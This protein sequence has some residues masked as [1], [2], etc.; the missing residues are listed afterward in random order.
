MIATAPLLEVRR[1][2]KVFHTAG[3]FVGRG[4]REVRA[5]DD[6]SFA[7]MAGETFGLVGESG[8]GKSTVARCVLN[9]IR[10]TAGEVLFEGR[11]VLAL[12]PREMRAVRRH[13]QIIFQD[14][15]GSLDPRMRVRALVAEPLDIHGVGS[16]GE[17]RQRVRALLERVGL[18]ES[19]LDKFPHEFSGGQRQRIGIARALAL[20]PRLILADEPVSALD[21]SIRAQVINLMMELQQEFGLTYVFIAHDLALVRQICDRVAVMYRGRLVELAASATLFE[22]P[23]HPY[24]RRLLA[25]IPIP[26]PRH[27]RPASG[28]VGQAV[29]LPSGNLSGPGGRLTACPTATDD[30]KEE[31]A[32]V[33]REVEPQHWVRVYEAD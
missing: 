22:R 15:Y 24:T 1:L 25:A 16:R 23:L 30:D 28:G 8:C 31:Q 20:S 11:D 26:D 2:T 13:L 6:V 33:W 7:V 21:L 14:P 17:R 19:A 4:A 12:A 27:R 9:L 3:R 5:V 32:G 10:P 18:G 29:S